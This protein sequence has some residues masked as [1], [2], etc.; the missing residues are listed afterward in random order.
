MQET[1]VTEI[2]LPYADTASAQLKLTVG[3]CRLKVRPGAGD[4]WVDGTY[5]DPSGNIPAEV[6][7][8]GEMARI[9]Q[10]PDWPSAFGWF[11]HVPTFDL[12]LG[13]LNPYILT[14]ETGASEAI[15]DLGGL[16]LRELDIKQGAGKLEVDFSA[17]NPQAMER[18][19]LRGGA[20]EI[21]LK[22]L[23]NANFRE[24]IVE[25]GAAS[26]VFNFGGELRQ[27][28]QLRIS[29]GVSAV[30]ITL[31]AGLASKVYPDSV[32]GSL[33]MGDGFMKKE[34]AYWTEAAL[35]GRAPVLTIRT[36]V[37]LGALHLRI[38]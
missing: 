4:L 32:L 14:I 9:T 10:Q 26:Y 1:K 13:K 23:A 22:N 2:N 38:V 20:G 29:T 7:L 30:E 17:P 36:T 33:D 27:D 5:D 11:G 15:C 18:L 35:A 6:R 24:M 16:P 3:A 28:A 37:A 19:A 31:P 21:D 8:E 25:G 12:M 34:G